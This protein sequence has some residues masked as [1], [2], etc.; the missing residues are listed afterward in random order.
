MSLTY[1]FGEGMTWREFCQT[2]NGA[3]FSVLSKAIYYTP[4]ND[5]F[6]LG[7]EILDGNTNVL[8]DDKIRPVEYKLYNVPS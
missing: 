2:E 8:P 1:L 5:V 7:G 3:E 4:N 6:L